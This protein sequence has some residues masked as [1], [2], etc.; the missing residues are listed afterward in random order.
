M[1][2]SSETCNDE[3]AI[4]FKNFCFGQRLRTFVQKFLISGTIH[5]HSQRHSHL[6]LD[7]GSTDYD[8]FGGGFAPSEMVS[9][10]DPGSRIGWLSLWLGL[11]IVPEIKNFCT[12]VLNL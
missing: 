10:A 5:S 8:E 1:H 11:W 2:S 9:N 12:K 6:I 3:A 4:C 7:P